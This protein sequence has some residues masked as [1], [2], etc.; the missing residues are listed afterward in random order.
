MAEGVFEFRARGC[1]RV[2]HPETCG[3]SLSSG[4]SMRFFDSERKFSEGTMCEDKERPYDTWVATSRPEQI[5]MLG[6]P[7]VCPSECRAAG[8]T[9]PRLFEREGQPVAHLERRMLSLASEVGYVV[10][11]SVSAAGRVLRQIE[12]RAVERDFGAPDRELDLDAEPAA[13][14]AVGPLE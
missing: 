9:G 8:S 2:P 6:C 14:L 5:R 11:I 7:D 1:R 10:A 4:D 12:H 13:A 3:V